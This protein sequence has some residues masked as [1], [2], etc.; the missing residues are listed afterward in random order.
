MA[1]KKSGAARGAALVKKAIQASAS[2]TGASETGASEVTAPEPVPAGV[3][4][5]LRLP[6]DEKLPAGLKTFLAHDASSLGWSFDDEEPEFEPMSLDELV[7]QEFGDEA[8]PAFGEAVELLEGDCILIEAEGDAKSFL[9]V[10]EPDD[11]GEYPVITLSLGGE[12]DGG[13]KVSG[14][15]PFDVWIAQRFGAADAKSED[16]VAAAQ[17]LA[18][19][20]GDG[21][22]EFA[23]QTRDIAAAGGDEDEDEDEDEDGGEEAS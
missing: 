7:A 21:R 13:A 19:S 2:E 12:G 17:A 6:N 1:A 10:G 15:V 22:R 8:V 4:K 3:L 16:Y 23:S 20:N 9:Y 14:F 11:Q 18:E 5:K